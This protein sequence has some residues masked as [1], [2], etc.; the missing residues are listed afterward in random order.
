V[1]RNYQIFCLKAFKDTGLPDGIQ[2][3][4]D[5]LGLVNFDKRPIVQLLVEDQEGICRPEPRSKILNKKKF[6]KVNAK[7]L[8]ARRECNP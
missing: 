1:Y 8:R 4:L 3:I 6:Q 2:S 7:T 5:N